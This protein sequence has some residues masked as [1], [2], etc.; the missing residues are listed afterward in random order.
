MCATIARRVSSTCAPRARARYSIA[1]RRYRHIGALCTYCPRGH[2]DSPVPCG[3][4]PDVRHQP[5]PGVPVHA[6][7]P[8]TAPQPVFGGPAP[9]PQLDV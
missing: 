3:T 7:Q 9:P 6:S 2:V 5:Q 1:R 4:Q 8:L